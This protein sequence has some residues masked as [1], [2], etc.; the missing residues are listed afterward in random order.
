[1]N[2]VLG[3]YPATLKLSSSHYFAD[4]IS[5]MWPDTISLSLM[6][7]TTFPHLPLKS[8]RIPAEVWL[9]I[10]ED[11]EFVREDIRN[12]TL[13]SKFVR[14]IAQPLLFRTITVS[15]Y[16]PFLDRAEGRLDRIGST[17]ATSPFVATNG[18]GYTRSYVLRLQERLAF[19]T[20]SRIAHGVHSIIICT[21]QGRPGLPS[22]DMIDEEQVIDTVFSHLSHFSNMRSFFASDSK[23][24]GKHFDEL[25]QLRHLTGL[26]FDKCTGSGDLGLSRFRLKDLSLHG[27]I[28]GSFG[29]WISLLRSP[30]LQRL[31]YSAP[32]QTSSLPQGRPRRGYED[33]L[34]LFFPALSTGPLMRDLRVLRLPSRAA[35]SP[36]YVSALLRCPQ[37]EA[38]LIDPGPPQITALPPLPSSALPRLRAVCASQYFVL[39][40]LQGRQLRHI[41]VDEAMNNLHECVRDLTMLYPDIEELVIS[42]YAGDRCA[43]FLRRI[44]ERFTKLQGLHI[45]MIG[46]HT[47]AGAAQVWKL[48]SE[49]HTL[50]HLM[51]SLH[52]LRESKGKRVMGSGKPRATSGLKKSGKVQSSAL[53]NMRKC[54]PD[55]VDVCV[56]GFEKDLVWHEPYTRPLRWYDWGEQKNRAPSSH[57]RNGPGSASPGLPWDD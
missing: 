4:S 14:W 41:Q 49:P 8:E 23:L 46:D 25:A 36:C 48:L 38:L 43:E 16:S 57:L 13:V 24:S 12:L 51:R 21:R 2:R 10:I 17:M 30:T 26:H 35:H 22:E 27:T 42:V 7:E 33:S 5:M 20:Q 29:W 54:C 32:T 11:S 31:S 1:M 40:C 55:L 9:Q 44:F 19:S 28:S 34:G 56:K 52:I 18:R 50:S 3:Y 37:V 15:K 47:D 6:A 53:I 39:R 45:R